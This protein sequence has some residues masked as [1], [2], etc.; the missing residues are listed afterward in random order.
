[1]VTPRGRRPGKRDTRAEIL[2]AARQAFRAEGYDR[3]TI[4][5][6]ARRAAVDP[7]LVHHYFGDKAGLFVAAMD[8]ARD[9]RQVAEQLSR[10]GGP[11][12]VGLVL[13]FLA[14]WEG[15]RSTG[16]PGSAFV[17]MVQAAST[18][19]EV[20]T[21]LREFLS[22]RV[23]RPEGGEPAWAPALVS[24]QL[25]GIGWARYIMRVEPIASATPEEVAAFVGP[26]IDRYIAGAV[27]DDGMQTS[28]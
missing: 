3:A 8:L 5:S 24:S 7:S 19:P 27:P 15:P 18:A 22:E 12:G 10:E 1:M 4:R 14:I 11:K 6:V 21:A 16:E 13:A 20:A 23:W 17:A 25:A 2:D 9:P 26:T 28:E